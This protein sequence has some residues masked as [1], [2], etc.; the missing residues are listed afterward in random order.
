MDTATN[1]REIRGPPRMRTH[2]TATTTADKIDSIIDEDEKEAEIK[3]TGIITLC[4]FSLLHLFDM[5]K[6]SMP[7]I[8]HIYK[9]LWGA[10]L[11]KAMKGEKENK[12]PRK[13]NDYKTVNKVQIPYTE[14]QMIPREAA[15][16]LAKSRYTETTAVCVCVYICVLM[17]LYVCMCVC[18]CV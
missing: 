2:A 6:D 16:M 11:I 10:W 1:E 12:P 13:P 8:M 4:L 3:R 17:C 7:D 14:E 5:I 18:V 9:N 15:Y